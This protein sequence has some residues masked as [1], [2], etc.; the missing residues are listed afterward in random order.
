MLAYSDENALISI[1]VRD[2]PPTEVRRL[3]SIEGIDRDQSE[4]GFKRKK[5]QN[6]K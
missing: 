4:D 6:V 2:S 5:R 3:P 1:G